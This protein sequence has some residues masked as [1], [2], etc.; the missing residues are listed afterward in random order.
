MKMK[1]AYLKACAKLFEKGILGKR[2]F[3]KDPTAC[4]ELTNMEEGLRFFSKWLDAKL[5]EGIPATY[6]LGALSN[7]IFPFYDTE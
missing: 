3:I 2:T 4:P 7:Y 6:L 1:F 5:L